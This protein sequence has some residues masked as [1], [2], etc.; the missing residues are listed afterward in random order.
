[1][2]RNNLLN[3]IGGG[4][5]FF[6]DQAKSYEMLIAGRL[7]IGICAGNTFKLL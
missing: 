3:L 2:L 6:S 4:L 1:M 5:M 7:V